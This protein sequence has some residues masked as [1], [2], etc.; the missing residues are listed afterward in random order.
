[1]AA[2]RWDAV[3]GYGHLPGPVRADPLGEFHSET[4]TVPT[5]HP[6]SPDQPSGPKRVALRPRR[7]VR[8]LFL[9]VTIV[10]LLVAAGFGIAVVK[11]KD[12]YVISPGSAAQLT[13]SPLCHA[14]SNGGR[15]VLPNGMACARISVPPTRGHAMT[16][17]LYM[18]DVLVGP[19][20]TG[21][22]LLGKLGLLHRFDHGAQ[23]VPAKAVLGT[24][25][26]AQLSCQAAQQMTG[27]TFSATVVALRHLGYQ[28]KENNL[29]AQ[30]YEVAP[31]SPASAA[32]LRCNDIVIAVNDRPVRTSADLENAIRAGAPGETLRLTVQRVGPDGR[33][34]TETVPARL[35][36]PPA[37]SGPA[38]HGAYLGV[39]SMTRTTYTFPFDI[40][41]DVGAVG[42][43]SA[44][45]AFTLAILDTLSGGDLTGGHAVAVTGT[46][47]LNGAVGDVGGVAQKAV[48][49][50]RAGA[51]VF[52]VPAGQLKEA[53]SQAG[54]MKIYPVKTLEQALDDLRALGG[55]VPPTSSHNGGA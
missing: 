51:N 43:P 24:T 39:V 32:G 1:V 20:S 35:G 15:L 37:S 4:R 49:A 33:L 22:Y 31:G 17:P 27:A 47:E 36:A 25:P 34:Q 53:Q 42:G 28:V 11:A 2:E 21:Q 46:I 52:L 9:A 48:V 13:E 30:L 18:V 14:S 10:V 8:V 19:S 40:K 29:G 55:H 50:Q 45:L 38:R 16:G 26:P 7:P 44:G 12:Y 54:S 3:T 23:M 41:I 6:I 5:T